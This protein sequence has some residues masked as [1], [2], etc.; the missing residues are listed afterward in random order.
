MKN[1]LRNNN[2]SHHNKTAVIIPCYNAG[3]RLKK[4]VEATLKFPVDVFVVDDGSTDNCIDT[5]IQLPL[6]II[7]LPQNRGKGFA[8][9]EGLKTSLT[10][11]DYEIFCFLDADGQHNPE[12]LPMFIKMW[13]EHKYDIIIGQRSFKPG[14]VPLASKIG[15]YF[16]HFILRILVKCPVSDTQCGFRLYSR[17]FA[18]EIIQCVKPGRYETETLILLLA[19][20]KEKTIG[21]IP[22]PSIYEDKNRSSHFRKVYDSF[23]ILSAIIKY[24]FMNLFK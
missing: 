15:N 6:H 14:Q 7:S 5:I 13:E 18:E 3:N 12:L 21:T 16:T 1:T 19:I 20:Q 9:I 24:S 22:I 4:V 10:S 2:S 8:I 17:A 23:R 11:K